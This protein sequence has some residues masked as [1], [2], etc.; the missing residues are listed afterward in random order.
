[1]YR[2]QYEK[3]AFLCFQV[4]VWEEVSVLYIKGDVWKHSGD[5]TT[6]ENII[7]ILINLKEVNNIIDIPP[8]YKLIR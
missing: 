6:K 1:M 8:I 7:C 3:S 5:G 4:F 2:E